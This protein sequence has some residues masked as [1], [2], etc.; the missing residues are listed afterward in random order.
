MTI[1]LLLAHFSIGLPKVRIKLLKLSH[2]RMFSYP[3]ILLLVPLLFVLN[4]IPTYVPF[5]CYLLK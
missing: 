4:S 5:K 1:L 3:K 2:A